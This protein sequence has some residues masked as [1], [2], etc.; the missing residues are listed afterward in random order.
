MFVLNNQTALLKEGESIQTT[1][2][3]HDSEPHDGSVGT[4][5]EAENDA[6]HVVVYNSE[7]DMWVSTA[8]EQQ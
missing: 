8:R 5:Y 3:A 1:M 4:V 6:I 2:A 7:S